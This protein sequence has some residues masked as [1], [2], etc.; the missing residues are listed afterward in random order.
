M[1]AVRNYGTMVRSTRIH[2]N[3][4]DFMPDLCRKLLTCRV[5]AGSPRTVLAWA[6]SHGVRRSKHSDSSNA[7]TGFL[8]GAWTGLDRFYEPKFNL[9]CIK[10]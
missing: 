1:K 7:T 9:W 10:T 2:D 8:L 6:T 5:G 4:T 3:G